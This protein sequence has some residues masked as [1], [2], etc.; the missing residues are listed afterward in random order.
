MFSISFVFFNPH[1]MFFLAFFLLAFVGSTVA[2]QASNNRHATVERS[3]DDHPCKTK[4]AAIKDGG[5]DA[6]TAQLQ[7]ALAEAAEANSKSTTLTDEYAA[8]MMNKSR[9]AVTATAA[10]ESSQS[11]T[12]RPQKT[13]K[14]AISN[15]LM[16]RAIQT[17]LYYLADLRDE[18]TYVWMREFLNHGHLD[19]KGRFNELDGLRC[20]GGWKYY[21][22]QLEQA[23]SFSITVQLA[24][25]RLSAQQQRNPFLAAQ[26]V[27]RSYEE[28]IMPSKISQTLRTVARSLESEWVPVLLEIAEEDRKR[29]QL[30]NSPP[31]IQT[32]AA[33]YQ[34]FWCER[35]VVAGGEGDDQGTPLHVLNSRIVARFCTRVALDQLIDELQGESSIDNSAEDEEARRAAIEWLRDFSQ[36]WEPKL[37]RGPNDDKRRSFGVAPPGHWQRLCDGA[38]ADDVTEAMWQELP[39]LFAYASDDTMRLYSPEALAARLR[40]ARAGVCDELICDLR[41][42]VLSMS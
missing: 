8:E 14:H 30:Y 12:P 9:S 40:R 28:T 15:L 21:L 32:A 7:A 31:Q 13:G 5:M 2:F 1:L 38:D 33:A 16:Q 19:D 39:P 41:S 24:P 3:V 34:A 22:E 17:Q 29:V 35:Q 6:F 37:K 36:E 25:P 27:G 4:L 10:V 20:N 18:P 42:T 26:A 11:S 23:P